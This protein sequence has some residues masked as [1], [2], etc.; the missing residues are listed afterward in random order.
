M[1]I[2]QSHEVV[3]F[4]EILWDLLPTGA[5]PGGAPMNVAYHL[6][7]L[8]FN[9]ALITRVG[10]DD[11]GQKLITMME[12]HD[13]TTEFFQLDYELS[14]GKVNA[15]ID[16]NNEVSYEIQKPVAW[17]TVQFDKSIEALV[18]KAQCL[19]FGTLASRSTVTRSTLFK[20]LEAAS[21]RV[22]DIN[23]RPPFFNKEL[24]DAFL[25][26][27]DLLKLNS[28]ELELL[29]GWYSNFQSINDRIKA[30]QDL[31][32]IK[33]IV[34]TKGNEG[35][36]FLHE[37]EIY[38]QAGYQINVTDTVGSGD[39]F[40]AGLL[41]RIL[42]KSSPHEALEFANAMGAFVATQR[43]ACPEYNSEHVHCLIKE[44]T[45]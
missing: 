27:V 35:A 6:K 29:T 4:G 25:R 30:I 26:K 18:S 20:L 44:K 8:G 22:L 9:P 10:L 36:L 23:L 38:T 42:N 45:S 33:S 32:K 34:V 7:K 1:N 16:S 13:L 15:I 17:D 28:S 37:G 19:V 24:V 5:M 14:T 12:N 31:F 43:G 21:Y 2:S 41:S 11:W 3:C 40:L 39:A